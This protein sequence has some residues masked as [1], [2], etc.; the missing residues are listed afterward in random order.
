[1]P[2]YDYNC[3]DCDKVFT[4]AKSMNDSS[5]PDCPECGSANVAKVWGNI[6]FKGCGTKG[7][8]GG[9]SGGCGGCTG[10]SC[11]SCH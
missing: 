11:S 7:S 2:N 8:S 5:V 4:V 3:K 6:Q 9:G 10:G 1:M